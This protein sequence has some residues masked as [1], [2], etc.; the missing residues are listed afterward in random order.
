MRTGRS[1]RSS[2]NPEAAGEAAFQAIAK[3]AEV[4]D[5]REH[6]GEHPRLGATDVCPFVPLEGV[7]LA[8]CA[9]IARRVGRRVGDELGIPVY[10]YEAPPATRSRKNL[11]D[12]RRGEY[13]GLAE[14]LSDGFWPPDC[15]P[16]IH[17]LRS[18]ATTTAPASFW[19]PLTSR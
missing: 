12:V 11:A 17:N 3:A 5:M 2:A 15:G 10:F 1:S 16:A 9:A 8:E 18:G 14:R 7:T 19:S 6:C 4:I 13:E